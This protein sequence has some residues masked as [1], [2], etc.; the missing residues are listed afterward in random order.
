MLSGKFGVGNG[1][2]SAGVN[3]IHTTFGI[4]LSQV[5][6]LGDQLCEV[7]PVFSSQLA[8]VAQAA[9]EDASHGATGGV[10]ADGGRTIIAEQ[11]IDEITVLVTVGVT[12]SCARR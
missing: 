9:H 12:G 3:L 1:F 6:T 2:L 11:A 10:I 7:G 5:G 8:V 4:S